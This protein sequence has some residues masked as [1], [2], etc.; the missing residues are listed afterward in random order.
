MRKPFVNAFPFQDMADF[1][2]PV[3]PQSTTVS[4]PID[5]KVRKQTVF[6]HTKGHFAF[7][8]VYANYVPSRRNPGS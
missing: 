6:T 4:S 1:S 3:S 5:I 8:Y 7:Y 2:P